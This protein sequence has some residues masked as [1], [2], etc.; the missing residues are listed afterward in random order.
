MMSV[1]IDEPLNK[2]TNDVFEGIFSFSAIPCPVQIGIGF[3]NMQMGI[4]GFACIEVF[5]TEPEVIYGFPVPAKSFPVSIPLQI[6]TVP[7]NEL[8]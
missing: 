4:H 3:Q 2:Q 7:L 8:E 6:K 1:G 5:L